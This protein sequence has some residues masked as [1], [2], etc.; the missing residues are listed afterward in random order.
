MHKIFPFVC[1]ITSVNYAKRR[2]FRFLIRSLVEGVSTS[3]V[4]AKIVKDRI[5]PTNDETSDGIWLV[6]TPQVPQCYINA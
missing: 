6:V 1:G 3:D 5:C 4:V 2:S